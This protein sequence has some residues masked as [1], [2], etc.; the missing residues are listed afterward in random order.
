MGFGT[1]KLEDDLK[2]LFP[3]AKIQRMDQDTTRSKYGYQRIIDEFE[4]EET[5]ILVGTQMLSKGLHFE[6]VDLVGIFDFDRMMGFPDFRSH[7]RTFQMITQVSGRAGRSSHHGKVIIQTGSPDADLLMKIMR[8]DYQS[9]FAREILE[10]E[11]FKYPPFHRMIKVSLKHKDKTVVQK[12][13]NLLA[14]T[15]K[16]E[17]GHK[18]ILGPQT[19]VVSRI[20]NLYIEDIFI[21]VDKKEV[22]MK[23]VKEVV[24]KLSIELKSKTQYSALRVVFDVDPV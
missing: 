6:K 16:A 24:Y 23:K 1:E 15:M 12:A 18:R 9:F 13:V 5:N 21:K 20:R 11:N 22:N 17:L 14:T 19:P 8:G 3:T 4:S 2:L 10:R 7:E